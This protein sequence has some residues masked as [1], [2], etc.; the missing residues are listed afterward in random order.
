MNKEIRKPE[1][2]VE[3]VLEQKAHSLY[4]AEIF[5]REYVNSEEIDLSSVSE[6]AARYYRSGFE[7]KELL[8]ATL[9]TQNFWA[10][11]NRFSLIKDPVD[12]FLGTARTMGMS[13]DMALDFRDFNSA[14]A[15]VN[16][17]S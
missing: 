14:F 16:F 12:L 4:L 3:L 17:F 5:Y 7:I 11:D 13:D 15:N 6:I 8:K 9:E 1:E 10:S 2:A